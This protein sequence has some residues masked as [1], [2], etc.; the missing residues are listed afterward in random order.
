LFV[1]GAVPTG[2]QGL[3]GRGQTVLVVREAIEDRVTLVET[4]HGDLFVAA[5]LVDRGFG[6]TLGFGEKILATH[7]ERVVEQDDGRAA[8]G[9]GCLC[10][11]AAG[12]EWTRESDHDQE[13]RETAEQH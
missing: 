1:I 13:Q 5:R 3:H 9:V 7:A 11:A 8:C 12:E 10:G 2:A 6:S 4:Q